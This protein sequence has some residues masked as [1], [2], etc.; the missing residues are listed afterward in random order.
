MLNSSSCSNDG[1]TRMNKMRNK[2]NYLRK[3]N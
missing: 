1:K 2:E 3:E